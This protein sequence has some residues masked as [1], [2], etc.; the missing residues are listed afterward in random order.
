M[1]S[2]KSGGD[3]RW[4]RTFKNAKERAHNAP[5]NAADKVKNGVD[6]RVDN[7]TQGVKN[8]IDNATRPV[9]NAVEFGKEFAKAKGLK[10]KAGA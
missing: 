6:N 3:S 8:G 7:T 1:A 4:S 5:K 10:A 9:K 2:G